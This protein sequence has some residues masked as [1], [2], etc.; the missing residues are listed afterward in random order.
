MKITKHTKFSEILMKNPKAAEILLDTGM[1]CIG[2]PM[3]MQETL[4]EG[5]L[6][7]GMS[8]KDIDKL[9]KELNRK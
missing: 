2:C 7:H 9:I 6:A 8:N 5:C 3:A 4:E 1:A